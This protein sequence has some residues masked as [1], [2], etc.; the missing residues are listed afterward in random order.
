MWPRA[1]RLASDKSKA[2]S[3]VQDMRSAPRDSSSAPCKCKGGGGGEDDDDD[4]DADDDDATARMS[5]R[6]IRGGGGGEDEEA[7]A[8]ATKAEAT[9]RV[10]VLF[11]PSIAWTSSS[12]PPRL[13]TS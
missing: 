4:A 8:V 9:R 5:R 10:R 11:L 3:S 12:P 7:V 1:E 6:G 2:S 13:A